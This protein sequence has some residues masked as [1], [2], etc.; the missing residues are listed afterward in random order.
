MVLQWTIMKMI[1]ISDK[2]SN[3]KTAK[4]HTGRNTVISL[5]YF[6]GAGKVI[7]AKDYHKMT[8]HEKIMVRTHFAAAD[9]EKR[10]P[11]KLII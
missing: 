8:I 9:M 4:D 2:T 6:D 1:F 11:S 7:F 10:K 3:M 5:R